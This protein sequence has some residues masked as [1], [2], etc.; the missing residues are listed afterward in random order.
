MQAKNDGEAISRRRNAKKK[1]VRHRSHPPLP[2]RMRLAAALTRAMQQDPPSAAAPYGAG[3]STPARGDGNRGSKAKTTRA[4]RRRDGAQARAQAQASADATP[5]E[6]ASLSQLSTSF[7]DIFKQLAADP[8]TFP[9]PA[10][11]APAVGAETTIDAMGSLLLSVGQN[12]Q[13]R[14]SLDAARFRETQALLAQAQQMRGT[15]GE[16]DLLGILPNLQQSFSTLLGAS[17]GAS[18][19]PTASTNDDEVRQFQPK[20]PPA[21]LSRP[22][23][24][25]AQ[26]EDEFDWAKIL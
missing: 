5:G 15:D 6:G 18:S 24:P 22:A 13:L 23:R 2:A 19:F 3:A 14:Q 4:G 7:Q 26:L 11:T 17:L 16:A 8:A 9:G 1:A 21:G 10:S 12:D 25:P 20:P